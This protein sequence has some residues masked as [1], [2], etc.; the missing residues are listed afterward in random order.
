M[1]RKGFT[2]EQTI[3]KLHYWE[4]AQAGD[5]IFSRNCGFLPFISKII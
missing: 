4:A 5:D 3:G 1:S 2:P